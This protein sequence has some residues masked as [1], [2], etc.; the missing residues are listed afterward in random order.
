MADW[1]DPLWHQLYTSP[2]QQAI[3]SAP[4]P[5]SN[6][7]AY[8]QILQQAAQQAVPLDSITLTGIDE[9]ARMMD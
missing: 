5:P 6:D 3:L 9:T 2:H 8:I 4:T 1:S 7:P